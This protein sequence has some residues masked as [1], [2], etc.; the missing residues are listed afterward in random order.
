MP[1]VPNARVD[2]ALR[3]SF[4]VDPEMA[5]LVALFVTELP[6]R[7]G[8]LRD[9]FEA[10]DFDSVR[11]L[12]HQLKGA[13]GGYGFPSISEAAGRVEAEIVASGAGVDQVRAEV[14][15]LAAEC[16]RACR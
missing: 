4:A 7:I 9:A 15:A 10:G 2:E 8:V 11:R 13:G 6:T 1:N 14:E 5:E 16:A 3:S 12:A